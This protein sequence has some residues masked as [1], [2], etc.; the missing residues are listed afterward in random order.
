M[1]LT[2]ELEF[3]IY[4]SAALTSNTIMKKIQRRQLCRGR[5]IRHC[6]EESTLQSPQPAS[7]FLFL[8]LFF[9]A[10]EF[11][12]QQR[13]IESKKYVP[14]KTLLSEE[15]YKKGHHSNYLMS[16]C[17]KHLLSIVPHREQQT[18]GRPIA[19]RVTETHY[20]PPAGCIRVLC[21]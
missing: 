13:M 5:A 2:Y 12:T 11:L 21:E 10:T 15:H 8:H 14:F 18:S 17:R 9:W 7:E 19:L 16:N 4:S 20:S 3:S 1:N 6:L